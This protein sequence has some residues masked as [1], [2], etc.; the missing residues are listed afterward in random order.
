MQ[1]ARNT[2]PLYGGR[3]C[4]GTLSCPI[5]DTG[6]PK[7]D[8]HRHAHSAKELKIVKHNCANKYRFAFSAPRLPAAV[9]TLLALLAAAQSS[10]A[11][12]DNP[13]TRGHAAKYLYIWA[14][15]Q[16]RVAPDFLT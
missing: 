4:D 12:K 10:P 13:G 6:F 7:K 16:A 14:G 5:G 1:P 9:L 8:T 2:S 11:Q 15:D 3:V